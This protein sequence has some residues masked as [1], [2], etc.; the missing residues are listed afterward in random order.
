MDVVY[1]HVYDAGNFCF[2]KLVPGYFSRMDSRGGYSNG[3]GCG[4]DTASE[5]S[6]VRKYIVDSVLYWAE[7][8]HID[9]FRFDLVGLLD[10][11]TVNAIVSAVHEKHPHVIFYGEGWSMATAVTKPNTPMATQANAALTPKFAYFSDTIRDALR[12]HVFTDTAK[13]YVSGQP[14][15]AGNMLS[16]MRGTLP[17]TNRPS[18]II[19]YASCHDNMTLFDRLTLCDPEAPLALRVRQNNLAAA[20]CMLAQGV[21]FFHAGEEFLRSKPLDGGFVDNSYNL[22]DKINSLKWKNLDDPLY[23]QVRDYYQGLIAFRR[24]HPALRMTDPQQI[25]THFIPVDVGVEDVVAFGIT[26]GAGGEKGSLFVVL[27]P[28]KE[29]VQISLPR[30]EWEIF[31]AGQKA[32]TTCLGTARDQVIAEPVSALVMVRNNE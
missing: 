23:Q 15:L 25:A 14:G 24:A 9:G 16:C 22:P 27:N 2:N 30:G 31:I 12:G 21:P 26:T 10:A 19:N 17:W 18:Q 4:N 20:I 28:G 5:R 1:N 3:S 13:G 8:Y 29:P 7:E 6:M 11:E 32:G